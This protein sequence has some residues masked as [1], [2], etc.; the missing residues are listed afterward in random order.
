MSWVLLT[1]YHY[2][3]GCH[4]RLCWLTFGLSNIDRLNCVALLYDHL[5]KIRHNHIKILVILLWLSSDYIDCFLQ[6]NTLYFLEKVIDFS[7]IIH[8]IL[9]A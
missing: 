1:L 2:Y 4:F 5:T 6:L 3:K 9:F 7:A 8:F